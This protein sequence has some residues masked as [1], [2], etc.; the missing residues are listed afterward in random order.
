MRI[1]VFGNQEICIE[2]LELLRKY[3][4]EIALVVGCETE[5][6]MKFGYHSVSEYCKTHDIPFEQPEVLDEEF[7]KRIESLKPDICFSFYFR[8]VFKKDL[9]DIPPMGFINLHPSHLPQYRGPAPTMWALLNGEQKTGV[10]LHYIDY[11][12]DTGDIIGQRSY[13]IP[14]DITG[15]ALNDQ[16]M[17]EGFL[18]IQD[19]M[20]KILNKTNDRTI[21]TDIGASYYGQFKSVVSHINWLQK[22]RDIYN[23]VRVLTKPYAGARAK[24]KD[25]EVIIW[26]V[27]LDVKPLHNAFGPGR[28]MDLSADGSFM[29]ST[30]NGYLRVLDYEGDK[31]L[32]VPG[33][34]FTI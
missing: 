9:I 32:I 30:V 8:K 22:S 20:P 7:T 28:I 34:R 21:Q 16:G 31:E 15:F 23:Q 18:L 26:R 2:S 24:I 5:A 11:G 4:A 10:T 25:Q 33:E 13:E 1:V 29:V 12:V 6:D 14:S 3:D 17:K 19:E 27:A